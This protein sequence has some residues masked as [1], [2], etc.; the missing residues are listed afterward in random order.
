[1]SERRFESIMGSPQQIKNLDR[2]KFASWRGG[3]ALESD[4]PVR[5]P[6]QKPIQLALWRDW[7]PVC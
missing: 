4:V 6:V 3:R 1:M 5:L 7:D 2:D